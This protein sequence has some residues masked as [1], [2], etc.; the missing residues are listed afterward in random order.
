MCPFYYFSLF[1][2]LSPIS[3]TKSIISAVAN[4]SWGTLYIDETEHVLQNSLGMKLLLVVTDTL[5][6]IWSHAMKSVKPKPPCWV[7]RT[8]SLNPALNTVHSCCVQL[9]AACHI[10]TFH[11]HQPIQ[12]T[13]SI[14]PGFPWLRHCW[15]DLCYLSTCSGFSSVSWQGSRA[16]QILGD[17]E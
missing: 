5:S 17:K 4:Q 16:Q 11:C 1:W 15:A 14:F 3:L 12:G 6:R 10:F 2:F 8:G 7:S 13:T 9:T